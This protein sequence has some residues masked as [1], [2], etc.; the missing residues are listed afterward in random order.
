MA[1]A[2]GSEPEAGAGVVVHQHDEVDNGPAHAAAVLALRPLFGGMAREVQKAALD[3][4]SF[5]RRF[6]VTV[7][8]FTWLAE[9]IH[10]DVCNPKRLS[11]VFPHV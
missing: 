8:M 4:E 3:P 11:L 10:D 5:R 9:S 7:A 6:R 2:P 1:P